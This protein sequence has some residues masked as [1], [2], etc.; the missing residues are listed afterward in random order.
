MVR[1]DDPERVAACV[2]TTPN[3][4]TSDGGNISE[5]IQISHGSLWTALHWLSSA[6][7]SFAP[8]PNDVPKIAAFPILT[9]TITP[10]LADRFATVFSGWSFVVVALLMGLGSLWGASGC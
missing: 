2:L 6:A 7:T 9:I 3:T 5:G 4:I 8:G 1:L 10:T